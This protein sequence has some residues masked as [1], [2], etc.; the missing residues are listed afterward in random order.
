MKAW[1]ALL[2]AASGAAASA[3][4]PTAGD[5]SIA[6]TVTVATEYAWR[7]ISLSQR[8]PALQLGLDLA[9]PLAHDLRLEAGAWTYSTR[10]ADYPQVRL[11]T[12]VY[13]R[14]GGPLPW[15][16][17]Q[18]GLQAARY[19]FPQARE[20]NYNEV[21]ASLGRSADE[22]V[23]SVGFELAF[24]QSGNAFGT[25]SKGHYLEAEATVRLPRSV[26]LKLHLGRSVYERPAL[27]YPSFTDAKVALATS[28]A[29]LDLELGWLVTRGGHFGRMGRGRLMAAVSR[30]F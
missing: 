24:S 11:D 9:R 22:A 19:V 6:A 27:T 18:W 16:G 30:S 25:G 15:H 8:K 23:G 4:A 10:Y 28:A 17:L 7:G 29:G 14:L 2:L 3:D 1:P 5:A 12:G 13:A 26:D 21:T 20:W